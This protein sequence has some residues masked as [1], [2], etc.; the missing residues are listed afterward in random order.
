MNCLTPHLTVLGYPA[1]TGPGG[2]YIPKTIQGMQLL[3]AWKKEN[4]EASDNWLRED[5]AKAFQQLL[6]LRL[7]GAPA[8]ELIAM[9]AEMWV[10]VIGE[11]MDEETDRDRIRKGFNLLLRKIKRWPQ[12]VELLDSLPARIR[13]PA[14]SSVETCAVDEE[15]HARGSAALSEILEGLK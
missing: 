3:L 10:T 8:A 11:N 15:A 4:A 5:I 14:A 1:R 2:A 6:I 7:D 12:P 13:K 9:T